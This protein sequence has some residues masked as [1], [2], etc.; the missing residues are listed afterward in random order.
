MEKSNCLVVPD[1]D[2]I[3][4]IKAS[5]FG[6][7]FLYKNQAYTLSLSGTHQIYNAVTAIEAIKLSKIEVSDDAIVCGI[8]K[9]TIPA[10]MEIINRKPLVILDGAH[11]LDGANALAAYMEAAHG[12][13]TAICGMMADKNCEGFLK[14][15]L[16]FCERVITVTVMENNRTE[17]A[18]NL[19]FISRKY[20]EKVIVCSSYDEALKKAIMN[21]K[22]NEALFVFG[23]LYLAGGIREKLISSF[24]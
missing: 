9:A 5:A 24:K 16:P 2:D 21:V 6:N 8:K 20:C 10:R 14:K 19:A 12:K 4:D 18:E 7:S 15:V 3:S 22:E 11:N 1:A 23:S 13:I 17:T